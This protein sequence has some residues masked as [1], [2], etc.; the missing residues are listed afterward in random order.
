MMS[1]LDKAELLEP[2]EIRA[3]IR[4]NI[5]RMRKKYSGI[6]RL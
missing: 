1:F 5:E 4:G 3:E 6:N 2:E